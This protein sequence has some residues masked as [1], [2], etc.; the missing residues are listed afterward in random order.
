M[1]NYNTGNAVPST[2]PRDLDDNATVF[3]ELLMQHVP[4]VPDRLGAPRKTWWQMEQDAAALVSPNVAALAALTATADKGIFFSSAGPAT[5]GTY[6]LTSFNRTLGATA[7]A[8][9]HRAAIGAIAL[10]D[11]GAYAG[12]AAKLTTAR[13]IAATG[14]ATWSVSFDGSANATAALTLANSGAAAGTYYGVTV[15]VKGRVTAGVA[16]PAFSNLTLQNGWTVQASRR[17]VYRKIN[18][19]VQLEVQIQAGTAT[20]GTVLF[21]LPAGNRPAAVC[22]VPVVGGPNTAL[23]GSVGLPRVV[24]QTNGDVTCVNC[25]TAAGI[26]FTA[27]IFTT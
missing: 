21:N 10:T 27:T 20:D 15:D 6:T 25:S 19:Y 2:D 3:D 8:V 22:G 26:S 14:D 12:S 16:T 9:A 11:T 13:N 24:F 4:S 17:A 23:S 7:D 18:D 1:S 5:M